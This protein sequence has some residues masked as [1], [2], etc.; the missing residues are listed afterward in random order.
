VEVFSIIEYGEY[1][2]FDK[3]IGFGNT[4][5]IFILWLGSFLLF[6]KVMPWIF[7]ASFFGDFLYGGVGLFYLGMTCFLV[8]HIFCIY[9]LANAINL[10]PLSLLRRYKNALNFISLGLIVLLCSFNYYLN[11]N[12][13][14]FLAISI[15]IC[16]LI[17]NFYFAMENALNSTQSKL[18]RPFFIGI[19]MISFIFCD[20]CVMIDESIRNNYIHNICGV[21]IWLFYYLA[22]LLI[23]LSADQKPL[24]NEKT[25]GLCIRGNS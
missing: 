16:F 8:F 18:P 25:K 13:I 24:L 3:L 2:Y 15:Y 7:G 10:K 21:L 6:E 11:K 1:K 12:K 5:I 17:N 4:T 9:R 22:Q 14:M 19:G 23:L 20:F